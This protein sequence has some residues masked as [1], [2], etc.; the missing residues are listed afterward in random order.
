MMPDKLAP[1]QR[2]VLAWITIMAGA[3]LLLLSVRLSFALWDY[4]RNQFT[5]WWLAN[6]IRWDTSYHSSAVKA[7]TAGLVFMGGGAI[8]LWIG[9]RGLRAC[10]SKSTNHG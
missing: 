5:E 4:T 10:R 8:L 7:A 2:H 6:P 3:T 1:G 9:I